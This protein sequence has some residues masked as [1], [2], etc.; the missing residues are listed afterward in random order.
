MKTSGN[1]FLIA[2]FDLIYFVLLC[3]GL[4]QSLKYRLK[5]SLNLKKGERT[6]TFLSE[7]IT[8]NGPLTEL[9]MP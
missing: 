8:P 5:K 3:V 4:K 6:Q 1:L 7:F 9:N 2:C